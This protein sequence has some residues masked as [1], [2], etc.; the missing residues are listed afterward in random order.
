M[1]KSRYVQ[2]IEGEEVRRDD[3]FE[4]FLPTGFGILHLLSPREGDGN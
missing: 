1:E 4:Y 3:P 2:V